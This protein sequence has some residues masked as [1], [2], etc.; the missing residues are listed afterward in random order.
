MPEAA[1][2]PQLSSTGSVGSPPARHSVRLSSPPPSQSAVASGLIGFAITIAQISTPSDMAASQSSCG[3]PPLGS[4]P[5]S[6][7]VALS[8]PPPSQSKA[9]TA[10]VGLAIR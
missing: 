2:L 6:H 9:P 7:S 10:L 3:E 8:I 4:V 5:A 1:K